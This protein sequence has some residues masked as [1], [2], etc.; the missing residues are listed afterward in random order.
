M[1]AL[2]RLT[3]LKGY[4]KI[5]LACCY[6][7]INILIQDLREVEVENAENKNEPLKFLTSL[8]ILLK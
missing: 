2:V 1:T 3:Y 4:K 7:F 6:Y 5:E 8:N